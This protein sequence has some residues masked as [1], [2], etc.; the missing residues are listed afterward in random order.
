MRALALA[1]VVACASPAP[2]PVAPP[3]PV[4]AAPSCRDAATLLRGALRA[5]APEPNDE[6]GSA[7]EAAIAAR[8]RDDR[9]PADVVACIAGQVAPLPCLDR[10]AQAQRQAMDAAVAAIHLPEAP[11]IASAPGCDAIAGPID[12]G[13]DGRAVAAQLRADAIALECT[14]ETWPAV[15]RQCV[16]GAADA[17]AQVACL[18]QLDRTPRVVALTKLAD[19]NAIAAR[20]LDLR[21]KPAAITCSAVVAA[22]YGDA[23]WTGKLAA[24]SAAAREHAI[25]ASRRLMRDACTTEHWSDTLRACLVADAGAA[26]FA[27]LGGQWRWDYPA[28]D[29]GP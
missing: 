6:I 22:H 12:R 26:C 11:G 8:C 10:L 5:S 13:D 21:G 4:P 3:R 16:H 1:I 20:A 24:A 29:A 9:W 2:P 23:R 18:D 14:R 19:A 17:A 7:R 25:A 28:R 27:A 15:V